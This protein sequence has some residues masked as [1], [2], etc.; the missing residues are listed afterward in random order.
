[1]E[2]KGWDVFQV[3]PPDS[4]SVSEAIDQ[5]CLGHIIRVLKIFVYI[6]TFIIVLGGCVI[7]KGTFL[8]MT[9]QIRPGKT[10]EHCN[11]ELARDKQY[12]AEISSAEQVR[13][14]L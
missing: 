2:T 9:S 13:T 6:L 10:I 8:F 5:R 14:R 11:K 1:M 7:S 3:L 12:Q 4:D